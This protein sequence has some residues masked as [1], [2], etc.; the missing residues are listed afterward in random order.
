MF[1]LCIVLLIIIVLLIFKIY[2]MKKSAKEI[3]EGLSEKLKDD[4]NTLISI[5]TNDKSMKELA[6][7][8][9]TQLKELR[10]QRHRFVQGDM[11]LKT[12]VTN[13]SHDLRTPLT[14][15]KGYLDLLENEEKSDT[16]DRYI[17]IIKNRTEVLEQLT[18]ELFRY[19][20]I[21]SPEYDDSTEYLSINSILEESI[22]GYYAILEERNITPTIH[23]PE[24]KI[25]RRL[26]KAALSR[27][28]SNLI[29]NAIKYSD[30]DLEITLTEAGEII[31]SNTASELNEVQVERLFDRF[32]TVENARKSTGLGLSIARILVERMNGT[33]TA[34]YK[35]NRLSIILRFPNTSNINKK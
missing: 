6:H 34:E 35:N 21:T 26:N 32:Y 27:V 2:I 15:I 30:G 25:I 33:I 5:S 20:I 19:S 23:I 9:N 29:N 28:F 7:K 17:N 16:V 4:T 11:E 12:A 24:Q 8:L 1:W 10:E 18:E 3:S 22:L 13:I 31:F 14:A